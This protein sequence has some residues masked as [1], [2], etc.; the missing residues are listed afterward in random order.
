MSLNF[1]T[2]LSPSQSLTEAQVTPQRWPVTEV[3]VCDGAAV[4][5]LNRGQSWFQVPVS[6]QWDTAVIWMPCVC[7]G[8][9]AWAQHNPSK[10]N[11]HFNIWLAKNKPLSLSVSHSC[12]LLPRLG[13][14]YL[15]HT[16]LCLFESI[17]TGLTW[18]LYLSAV[19]LYYLSNFIFSS[20]S[21][22][23]H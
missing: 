8:V 10:Q 21:V 22:F 23:C 6:N 15:L 13:Q 12:L 5:F 2:H 4:C 3:E 7:L 16:S 11:Q 19:C 20:T 1:L 9:S 17:S 18:H 14:P